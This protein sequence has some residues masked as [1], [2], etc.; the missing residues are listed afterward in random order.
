MENESTYSNLMQ[1]INHAL[2][3]VES[4]LI[5]LTETAYAPKALYW[6]ECSVGVPQGSHLAPLLFAIVWLNIKYHFG[7]S[8]S[9]ILT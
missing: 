6:W 5:F 4:N 8:V 3:F 9:Q 7:I 1:F 2:K